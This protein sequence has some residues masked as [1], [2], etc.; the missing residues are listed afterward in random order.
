[1]KSIRVPHLIL[2]FHQDEDY[3]KF[4]M[5][6]K[7]AEGFFLYPK[8][9]ARQNYSIFTPHYRFT[10]HIWKEKNSGRQVGFG[11]LAAD[12]ICPADTAVI[13]F[14]SLRVSGVPAANLLRSGDFLDYRDW[15]P[16]PWEEFA[17]VQQLLSRRELFPP[18]ERFYKK[19]AA[20]LALKKEYAGNLLLEIPYCGIKTAEAG[21]NAKDGVVYQFNIGTLLEL[22]EYNTGL[23]HNRG[24]RGPVSEGDNDPETVQ[25]TLKRFQSA[26]KKGMPVEIPRNDQPGGH[27]RGTVL[28]DQE[29]SLRGTNF[30]SIKFQ[31][32]D[33]SETVMA[34][35]GVIRE[36][37]NRE[38]ANIEEALDKIKVG[39]FLWKPLLELLAGTYQPRIP[40]TV[41]YEPRVSPPP[42]ASQ[43]EAIRKAINTE[44]FLLVQGPPGTG[45]TTIIVEM[46]KYF[47]SHGQ[48][49]LL[50]SK[51]NLAVDNVV[52]KC[53]HLTY[54][55]KS[56]MGRPVPMHCIRIGDTENIRLEEVRQLT[57]RDIT[58]RVQKSVEEGSRAFVR[59]YCQMTE[60]I[61]K[62]AGGPFL[63]IP[64]KLERLISCCQ[65]ADA[66]LRYLRS[67]G[68]VSRWLLRRLG[69]DPEPLLRR[70]K[71]FCEGTLA[72]H[73]HAVNSLLNQYS[74]CRDPR[75]AEYQSALTG[76]YLRTDCGPGELRRLREL[77][78]QLTPGQR[79]LLALRQSLR[80]GKKKWQQRTELMQ[81]YRTEEE[82]ETAAL[83]HFL[84][85]LPDPDRKKVEVWAGIPDGNLKTPLPLYGSGATLREIQT[86]FRNYAGKRSAFLGEAG[87]RFHTVSSGAAWWQ[88]V[89]GSDRE[90]LEETM[91]QH[92]VKIYAATCMGVNSDR[93]LKDLEYDVAIVDEAGQIPM[94]DL[95]VP[96]SRSR[97]VILIGDHMQI[98]PIEENEFVSYVMDRLTEERRKKGRDAPDQAARDQA[99]RRELE[100]LFSVSLFERLYRDP[101]LDGAK[102]LL[103]RQFRMHPAVAEFISEEFYNGKYESGVTAADRTLEIAGFR[104]PM[105]FID[106]AGAPDRGETFHEPGYSNRLESEI[107]ANIL[108]KIICEIREKPER[109]GS[110]VQ[111]DKSGRITYDLGVISGYNHQV[112]AIRAKT[113]KKLVQRYGSEELADTL[114]D[115]FSI[116]S[117]D[118]F[119]G[120]DNQIILFTFVRSNLQ[121]KIGFLTDVRRLNVAM[122]RCRSLLILVGDSGTLMG[123]RR[124][125]KHDRNRLAGSYYQD[126]ICYCDRKGFR[127]GCDEWRDRRE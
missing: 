81:K 57:A 115:R 65:A 11:I 19:H 103:N 7:P 9:D 24:L 31:N 114:L 99:L 78:G 37:M 1:M 29:L 39:E 32:T 8:E 105:Y 16:H 60:Q 4:R 76:Q 89:L 74:L 3:A 43:C 118:S 91:V 17:R 47:V 59:S 98:P 20:I 23:Q 82:A 121:H 94:Y 85:T 46:V 93:N 69:P 35:E 88:Q 38:F 110:L 14:G 13:Q 33:I 62:R 48:R 87:S 108:L 66:V 54:E 75:F 25:E 52:V 73:L 40:G 6:Y 18:A 92:F 63:Q 15:E 80:G 96:L 12:P 124:P 71:A 70:C 64:E 41:P 107:C 122:T 26:F 55:N 100:E 120:R 5:D 72:R 77:E 28:K 86:A 79:R 119:Q 10:A 49:V 112:E 90:Q 50:C 127:T 27:I 111:K 97:K 45:K 104:N 56:P 102:V 44:D 22:A 42:T 53:M 51:S 61:L 101:Q 67:C 68:R 126:L 36:T 109:Y 83:I 95:L 34:K 113:R 58:A 21:Q 106:T 117:V 2:H 30:L 84:S 116:N 123:C 125:A